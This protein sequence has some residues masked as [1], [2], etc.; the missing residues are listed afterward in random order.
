MTKPVIALVGANGNLGPHILRALVSEPFK[1]YYSLPIRVVTRDGSK[2]PVSSPDL[3]VYKADAAT[4]EGLEAAFDGANVVVNALGNLLSHAKVADAASKSESVKVYFPSEYGCNA[5]TMGP[6]EPLFGRKTAELNYA[7]SLPNLQVVNFMPGGF[8]QFYLGN[9]PVGGLNFPKPGQFM[10]YGPLDVVFSTTD[11]VDIGKAIASVAHRAPETIPAD[12][13]FAANNVTIGDI[14]A[15]YE[16][17][18]GDVLEDLALPLEGITDPGT[19]IAQEGPK[20]EREFYTGLGAALYAGYMVVDH[21]HN[22]F[23]T[24][25]DFEFTKFADVAK[26]VCQKP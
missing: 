24:N 22:D 14:K 26:V 17:F 20:S 16:A 2:L 23:V 4:G 5:T 15:A 13:R 18:T 7:R 8:S 1:N 6:Y 19:K 9:G 10:H 21:T 11:M 12:I 25:G 3:A